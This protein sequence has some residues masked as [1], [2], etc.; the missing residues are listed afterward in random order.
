MAQHVTI[1][2]ANGGATHLHGDV[3]YDSDEGILVVDI[4]ESEAT[5]NFPVKEG[6]VVSWVVSD[7]DEA[8]AAARKRHAEEELAKEREKIERDGYDFDH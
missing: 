8:E 4:L 1:I 3:M 5:A 6:Y 7:M 2:L